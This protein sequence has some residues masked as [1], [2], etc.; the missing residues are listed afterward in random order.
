M[1]KT[2]YRFSFVIRF[3]KTKRRDR[4]KI[5]IGVYNARLA[6]LKQARLEQN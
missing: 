3:M 6:D 1:L 2:M 4:M 5:S